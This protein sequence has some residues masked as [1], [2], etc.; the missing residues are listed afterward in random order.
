MQ[1]VQAKGERKET[2]ISDEIRI[3]G[4]IITSSDAIL[5]SGIAIESRCGYDEAIRVFQTLVDEN[6]SRWPGRPRL[7]EEGQ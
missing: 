5:S 7:L 2:T 3:T 1:A 6:M 4:T